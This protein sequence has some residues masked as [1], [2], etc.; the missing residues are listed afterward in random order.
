MSEGQLNPIA[1][2]PYTG[3]SIHINSSRQGN[4]SFSA[5]EFFALPNVTGWAMMAGQNRTCKWKGVN[6]TWFA[7]TYADWGSNLTIRFIAR[8]DFTSS[9]ESSE[10]LNN[11]THT[12]ILA[13]EYN[14]TV[15][16]ENW[17]VFVCPV[18][19]VEGRT[20]EFNPSTHPRMIETI[21]I[22]GESQTPDS[23]PPPFPLE[24][25]IIGGNSVV[26]V[27]GV[28]LIIHRISTSKKR[29]PKT[30]EV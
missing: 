3:F 11:A 16:D 4:V 25:V 27:V 22:I 6:F 29:V 26:M 1:G 24:L 30:Q 14:D 23:T 28:V 20:I 19:I 10:I 17:Q 5:T 12:Y 18:V 13:Y 2:A 15:M 21:L 9:F 8:D 7:E